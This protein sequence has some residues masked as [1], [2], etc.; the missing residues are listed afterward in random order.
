MTEHE[1]FKEA[2]MRYMV[3]DARVKRG[4]KTR[5]THSVVRRILTAAAC[6]ILLAAVSLLTI[7]SA[8][9]AVSEWF[10]RWFSPQDYLG[11][12]SGSRSPEPVMDAVI[13]HVAEA[14][15]DI[16]VTDVY[17][18]DQ[19]RAM[20]EG[21]DV[22]LDEVAYTGS[23]VFITGWF[24]GTSGKFLL[25]PY[26]GGDTWHEGN[27][28]TEGQMELALP[29][30]TVWY[31]VLNA[32]FTDEM[33][34]LVMDAF[35]GDP[36]RPIQMEYDE[37]GNFLTGNARADEL[38]YEWLKTHEVRFTF[39]AF[40]T[41]TDTPPLSGQV[42]AGLSFRQY[43][44]DVQNQESIPLFRADLG[45]VTIDADAYAAVTSKKEV[46]K[47]VTLSGVHRMFINEWEY[48]SDK[49]DEN[50]MSTDVYIH[51]YVRD[52]DMSDVTVTAE[53]VTFTPT[54]P[55]I[56]LRLNLP[57]SWTRAERVAAAQGGELGGLG[58]NLY[59]DGEPVRHLFGIVAFQGNANSE[60]KD[61]PFLT[62]PK[63]YKNS[64]LSPSDW[65][66]V[67]TIAF[68]PYTNWPGKMYVTGIPSEKVVQP[69]VKM[70][71]GVVV[72]ARVNHESG[73]GE[74]W[75]E[76]RMTEQRLTIQLDD[77]R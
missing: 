38:W 24:T 26:T 7:P 29:D 37:A 47:S 2:C 25:D 11:Q 66:K 77:Y 19:A 49:M 8:R 56:T 69:S 68:E 55:E 28:F 76:D 31:G 70:E 43:Y 57:E 58:F 73:Q 4:C 59:L 62:V 41:D 3:D 53:S 50:G 33:D 74:D 34:E 48:R 18:S 32:H 17:D 36:N 27:E 20:A 16:R 21:F 61:D 14:G 13:I 51:S 9:A 10:Y 15:R 63:V 64:T 30:G 54:G 60:Y 5:K 6:L 52:L 71:P 72:T 40:P 46:G 65:D 23:K 1:L 44:Y 42:T 12:E 75:R 39:E 67:K 35:G 45:T 22:K